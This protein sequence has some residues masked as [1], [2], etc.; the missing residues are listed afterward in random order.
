MANGLQITSNDSSYKNTRHFSIPFDSI[1]EIKILSSVS[2]SKHPVISLN[3]I[4]YAILLF[5]FVELFASANLV[6]WTALGLITGFFLSAIYKKNY[7]PNI[8]FVI[9]TDNGDEKVFFSCHKN[10]IGGCVSFFNM[11]C[12]EIFSDER[13]LLTA[14]G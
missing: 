4:I 8:V 13:V 2:P 14:S 7:R 5:T 11:F 12:K 10:Q 9:N 1:R 6:L 3:Y